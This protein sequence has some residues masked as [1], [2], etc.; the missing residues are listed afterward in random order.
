M[1]NKQAKHFSTALVQ[2]E[3]RR[4]IGAGPSDSCHASSEQ[5]PDSIPG[6]SSKLNVGT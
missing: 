6:K 4:Y 3:H 1:A 2:E 5:L